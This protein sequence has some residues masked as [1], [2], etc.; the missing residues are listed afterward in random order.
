ME[1]NIFLE[2]EKLFFAIPCLYEF[3]KISAQKTFFW[4]LKNC[5]FAKPS[6]SEFH[7]RVRKNQFFKACFFLQSHAYINF[8]MLVRKNMEP[9]KLFFFKSRASLSFKRAV[10]EKHFFRA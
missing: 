10:L 5:L 8:I 2:P 9:E 7:E 3:Y 4:S 1:K 6:F